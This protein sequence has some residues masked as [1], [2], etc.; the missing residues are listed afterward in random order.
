MQPAIEPARAEE[1]SPAS[2]HPVDAAAGGA[3]FQRAVWESLVASTDALER[4]RVLHAWDASTRALRMA[5]EGRLAS[6]AQHFRESE[7]AGESA[8]LSPM[9]QALCASVRESALAYLEFRRG[10]HAS[11]ELRLRR[12]MEHDIELERRHGM[13]VFYMH[14]VQLLHNFVRL[15]VH[16]GDFARAWSL[17]VR[18]LGHLQGALPAPIELAAR[19]DVPLRTASTALVA[20]M[21]CQVACELAK[22]LLTWR[23]DGRAVEL[24]ASALAPEGS[25]APSE[26][27]SA[28]M[29]AVVAC[30]RGDGDHVSEECEALLQPGLGR[31]AVLRESLEVLRLRGSDG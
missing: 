16:E 21:A 19:R 1:R 22:L 7:R 3:A 13:S 24:L 6:A 29:R 15:H 11:A 10:D 14:R 17:G 27:C 30:L 5:R 4:L 25:E 8:S 18:T 2:A 23:P 20:A 31:M 12:A 28:W 26:L 9:S